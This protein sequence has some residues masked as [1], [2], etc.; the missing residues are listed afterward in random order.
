MTKILIP[1]LA[2][3]THCHPEEASQRPKDPSITRHECP[4][5]LR[6][7]ELSQNDSEYFENFILSPN[8]VVRSSKTYFI[9]L[10]LDI[11]L[12]ISH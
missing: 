8:L 10:S 5:I 3:L 6:S 7:R 1:D 11:L 2:N 9:F 4:G 12:V